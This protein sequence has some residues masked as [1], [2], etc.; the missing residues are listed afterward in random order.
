MG[1]YEGLLSKRQNDK[2]YSWMLKDGKTVDAKDPN[3]SNWMR[4]VNCARHVK[5][6]NVVAFQYKGQMYYRTVKIIKAGEEML[7]Y[8]GEEFANNL[9][10][11]TDNYFKPNEE[12]VIEGVFPCPHCPIAYVFKHM[13]DRHEFFCRSNPRNLVTQFEGIFTCSYCQITLSTKAF[14]DSHE[15]FCSKRKKEKTE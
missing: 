3:K 4:Y 12:V 14:L 10:I 7:V 8:Y 6:Q 2:G 15:K 5:E 9:G 13:R 1:P 11:N